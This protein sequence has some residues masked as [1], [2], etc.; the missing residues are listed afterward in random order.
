MTT[1]SLDRPAT[2]PLV[3]LVIDMQNAFCD[4]AGS[5]VR[6]GRSLEGLDEAITQTAAAIDLARMQSVP[7]L[8]TRHGFS[9]GYS[10]AGVNQ[11]RLAQGLEEIGGLIRGTWDAEVIPALQPQPGDVVIEK[12]RFDAFLDTPLLG[13]LRHLGTEDVVVTGV[14][15][16]IC[17]E[18]TVRGAV[19]R[20][21]GVTVLADCCAGVTRRLHEISLEAIEAH[22]L[23]TVTTLA[24]G[25]SFSRQPL[26]EAPAGR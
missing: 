25:Y 1:A 10:D 19:M 3:L 11:R 4:P 18:T 13:I 9:P 20:D 26:A 12:T 24:G 23:A 7:I 21:F 2:A 15:T 17:V 8:Y 5:V 6:L 16:N 14:L 22:Q